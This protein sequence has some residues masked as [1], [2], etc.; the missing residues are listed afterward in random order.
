MNHP[1]PTCGRGHEFTEKNTYEWKGR[2]YCRRCTAERA[3][4]YRRAKSDG[5]GRCGECK[6]S[7]GWHRQ[8][9]GACL[10]CQ[11]SAFQEGVPGRDSN[12][13]PSRF[14]ESRDSSS[15]EPYRAALS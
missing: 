4:I 11:C 9:I 15:I 5:P 12:P 3:T 6:H 1:R 10:E 2:R 13:H 7:K 14:L 8:G